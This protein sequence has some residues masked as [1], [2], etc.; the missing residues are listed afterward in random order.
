MGMPGINICSFPFSENSLSANQ[1]R[2]RNANCGD[3]TLRNLRDG[4]GTTLAAK[5][6][7]RERKIAEFARE[8]GFR[9]SFY[10]KGLCAIFVKESAEDSPKPTSERV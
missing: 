8:F 1:A 10:R 2:V 6:Q 5:R 9:L 3:R 4:L 7:Y